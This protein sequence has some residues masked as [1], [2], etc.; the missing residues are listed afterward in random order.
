MRQ[1][2]A[3]A[4]ALVALSLWP[5]SSQAE[6]MWTP[7]NPRATLA[8]PAP[9]DA[10][11]LD[12][13]AVQDWPRSLVA[14]WRLEALVADSLALERC[15]ADSTEEAAL[16]RAESARDLAMVRVL[17]SRDLEDLDAC[18]EAL[19][20]QGTWKTWQVGLLGVGVGVGVAAVGLVI[21]YA[22]GF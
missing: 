18:R 16:C 6:E 10:L 9:V 2:H 17:H 22:V 19:K 14:K 11:Y 13:S 1:W 4:V 3:L 5:T 21:G 7:L 20:S 15:V 12:W 8:L